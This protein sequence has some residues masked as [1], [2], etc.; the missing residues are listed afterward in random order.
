MI[1]GIIFQVT[2]FKKEFFFE[3]NFR[4]TMQNVT[5]PHVTSSFCVVNIKNRQCASYLLGE[6][7]LSKNEFVCHSGPPVMF[8][9]L[10]LSRFDALFSKLF[11]GVAWRGPERPLFLVIWSLYQ[12]EVGAKPSGETRV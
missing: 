12:G 5:W 11:F 9:M 6:N 8:L 1:F 10:M 2:P 3:F 7:L 4:I